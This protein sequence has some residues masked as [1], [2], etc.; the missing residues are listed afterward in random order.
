MV[1]SVLTHSHLQK[2]AEGVVFRLASLVQTPSHRFAPRAL[3]VVLV[4]LPG[5]APAQ[6]SAVGGV[7][8]V[9]LVGSA[10][11]RWVARGS[12]PM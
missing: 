2:I 4:P 7:V 5:V 10:S 3:H 9:A 12:R 1:P 11:N 6:E 8:E